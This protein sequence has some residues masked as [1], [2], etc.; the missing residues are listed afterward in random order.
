VEELIYLGDH[1]RCRISVAGNDEFIVK[2]P[3]D[4]EDKRLNAG[5]TVMMGWHT[6][7]CRAL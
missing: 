7:D 6:A 4:A 3:N 1:I 5:E 2:I